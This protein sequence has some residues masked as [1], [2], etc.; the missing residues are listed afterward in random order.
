MFKKLKDWFLQKIAPPER[1]T[2]KAVRLSPKQKAYV[3]KVKEKAT[4]ND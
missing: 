1:K 2:V 4:K 3:R